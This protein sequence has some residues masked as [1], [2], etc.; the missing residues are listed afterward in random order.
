MTRDLFIKKLEMFQTSS[1]P[2]AVKE[3]AIKELK[4]QYFNDSCSRSKQILSSIH[5][6]SSEL[7][8]DE[9]F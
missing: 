6:S 1:A 5:A 4:E 9:L 8:A 7:K 3:K 2:I